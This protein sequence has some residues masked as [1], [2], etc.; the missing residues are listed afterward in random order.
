VPVVIHTCNPSYSAQIR[1]MEVWSQPWANSSWHPILKKPIAKKGLKEWLKQNKKVKGIKTR[2]SGSSCPMGAVQC[3]AQ[4]SHSEHRRDML[5]ACTLE[6][7]KHVPALV[8]HLL[9]LL[10]RTNCWIPWIPVS[11]WIKL[12]KELCLLCRIIVSI[13]L[14][15]IKF[16][17]TL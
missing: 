3:P 4:S 1:R 16:Q 15:N 12:E 2:V 9:T 8:C 7:V 6:S 14:N 5:R 17:N 10:P 13:K 11:F